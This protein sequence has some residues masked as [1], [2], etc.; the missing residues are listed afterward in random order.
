MHCGCELVIAI[1]V[2]RIELLGLVECDGC[3]VALVGDSYGI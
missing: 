1:L 2:Q 3:N